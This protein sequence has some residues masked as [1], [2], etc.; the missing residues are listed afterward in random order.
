MSDTKRL[1][2]RKDGTFRVLQL[3]D[4]QDGPEVSR[5]AIDLIEAAVAQADPDLVVLTG[6][7]IRGYD[8]AY[9]STFL[10][11]RGSKYGDDIPV[12]IKFEK[13]LGGTSYA[14]TTHYGEGLEGARQKV[15]DTFAQFLG[16][17]VS[18]GIPFA[19]TYGNHDF[20]CGILPEEQDDIYR[21]FSG[22]LNPKVDDSGQVQEGGIA[23]EAGTFALPV[24]SSD[25]TRT[26]MGIMMVNSGDFE[27]GGGYGAP[28]ETAIRWLKDAEDAVSEPGSRT[29]SIV[30]QHIPAQEFYQCLKKVSPFTPYAVEGYRAFSDSCYVVNPE[31]CRPGSK[32]G[33]GPCC[34]ER[35]VGEVQQMRDAGGYFALYCGHDHKNTFIGHVDGLD[36]GYAPTCG[37]CSYG[38][39]AE[40]H[41][42]R[43]FVFH[44]DQPQRYETRLLTYGDLIGRTVRDPARLL[45]G[46]YM[47]SDMSSVR[48]LLRRPGV[49]LGALVI[50]G[51]LA[52]AVVKHVAGKRAIGKRSAGKRAIGK[53]AAGKR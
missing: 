49:A 20:Q 35:N 19:A 44:E 34:S 2:F 40:D 42:L 4:V 52:A 28:S 9:M 21:E 43:L 32:L 47:I 53:C 39:K 24:E 45:A 6:D 26:A 13:L 38:P 29:P 16:P 22:C 8:P 14:E 12:G 27:P 11:R 33:E 30:F 46:E 50:A 10:S 5:D 17:I 7:Q 23:C 37:F 51:R 1:K 36:L 3:A 41:A 25:G 48:N 18:R 31:I 15:R